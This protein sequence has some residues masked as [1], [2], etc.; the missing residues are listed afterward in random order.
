MG[1]S[2]KKDKNLMKFLCTAGARFVDSPEAAA[3]DADIVVTM[4]AS[5]NVVAQAATADHG[6][7]GSLRDGALWVDMSTG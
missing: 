6:F 3:R 1:E 7:L 2:E 4:L 5:P